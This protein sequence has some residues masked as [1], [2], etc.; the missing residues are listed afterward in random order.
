MCIGG[1]GGDSGAA[2]Q[3]RQQE[4]ARNARIA[5]GM[6]QLND[7]FSKFDDSYYNDYAGKLVNYWKPDIG[8]Q[9]KDANDKLAFTFASSNPG[10]S[11]SSAR[12][13]A[14]LRED[15]DRRLL[16]ATDNATTQSNDL[17]K[18]V[19][20][21]RASL[22][23]QLNATADPAAAAN[24]AQN[25]IAGLSQPPAYEPLGDLFSNLTEQFAISQQAA[26]SGYPGW[27]FSVG[28][29]GSS[30]GVKKNGSMKVF[31]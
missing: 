31:N 11:S 30:G 24:A 9:F 12:A 8:R 27:G 19:E 22:V 17:R 15:R 7:Q 29:G 23:A 5:S 25:S 10:G 1:G 16:E 3:Q 18:N 26:R 20:G 21:Q 4:E 6:G 14:R 28:G 2:E 13:F